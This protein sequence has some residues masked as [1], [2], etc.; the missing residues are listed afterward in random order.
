MNHEST[1]PEIIDVAEADEFLDRFRYTRPFSTN[2]V[3]DPTGGQ[4]DVPSIHDRQFHALIEH[5]EHA[6]R[7]PCGIGV[8]VWG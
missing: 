6:R 7:E 1:P 5:A 4:I 2:R 3:T 8:V